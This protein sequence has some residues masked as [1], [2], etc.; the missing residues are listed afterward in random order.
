MGLLAGGLALFM[1]GDVFFRW[2]MGMRPVVVRFLGAATALVPGVVG[3]RW[4]AQG[5]LA[6]I[7]A[8]A[9]AVIAIERQLE[10]RK[11]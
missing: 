6:A 2:V 9:I 8:L 4:G 7:A 1:L 11:G 5:A 3:T 10:S